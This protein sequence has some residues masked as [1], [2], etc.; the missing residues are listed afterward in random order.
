MD[1]ALRVLSHR[2]QII[3]DWIR[4]TLSV[5]TGTKSTNAIKYS[6]FHGFPKPRRSCSWTYETNKFLVSLNEHLNSII[7]ERTIEYNTIQ[8]QNSTAKES[9]DEEHMERKSKVTCSH[10][11]DVVRKCDVIA[12]PSARLPA[13]R[14]K[15][16]STLT[17]RLECVLHFV[18]RKNLYVRT[19]GRER[20]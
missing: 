3:F 17:T 5:A 7:L 10:V 13:L 18:E 2:F 19:F 11:L 8:P 6:C 16:W 9:W 20:P 15:P 1:L 12:S 4:L 14:K